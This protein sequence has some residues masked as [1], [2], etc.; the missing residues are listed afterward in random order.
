M[1]LSVAVLGL[2]PGFAP[3]RE[4]PHVGHIRTSRRRSVNAAAVTGLT[5]LALLVAPVVAGS[6]AHAADA[7]MVGLYGS[8]DP[9]Y[10]G[11]YRQSLA[12]L[13]LQAAG[14]APAP[15][16]VAWLERQQCAAGGFSSYNPDPSQACPAFDPGTFTGGEDTNATA[17]AVP[18]LIAAGRT[19]AASKAATWLRGLQNSD[20]G[21]EYTAGQPDSDPNSTGL[22]L[23]ALSAAGLTPADSESSALDYLAGM[24]VGRA[25]F[26]DTDPADRGGIAS[27]W[28]G[29]APDVLATVQAVPGLTGANLLTTPGGAPW[30]D[31][32]N[33]APGSVPAATASGISHW[34]TTWLDAAADDGAISAGNAAWAILSFAW[35]R[36]GENTANGLY[37]D[38]VEGQVPA[39]NPGANGQAALAAAVLGRHGD[40]ATYAARI[41]ATLTPDTTGPRSSVVVPKAPKKSSSW[42]KLL[43]TATDV[44]GVARVRV[45]VNQKRSGTWYAFDGNTWTKAKNGKAATWVDTKAA[46]A[47]WKLKVT[48]IKTGK[49]V[50][51]AKG[52][53]VVGNTGATAKVTQKITKKK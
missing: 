7:D 13:G 9:T 19:G 43:V 36:R 51:R 40:V 23:T 46:G 47:A 29:G 48:G 49:L 18:A 17:V 27:P 52:T 45:A 11:V 44:S 41:A 24:Q 3:H 33:A 34:A 15:E 20:G 21:W 14:Q 2:G 16:A 26:A 28:S 1:L 10:D 5:T 6:P 8:T 35:D 32:V 4:E 53:D 50:V 38:L 31:G 30:R 22:V 37:D 25:D 42:K 39:T 12:I